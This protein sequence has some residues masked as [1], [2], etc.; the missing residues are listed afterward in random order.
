MKNNKTKKRPFGYVKFSLVGTECEKFLSEAISEGIKIFDV[1][2]DGGILYAKTYPDGYHFLAKLKRK[3]YIQM[4]IAEKRGFWL[5][6]YRYRKR[7]GVIFGIIAYSLVI[8]LC[9]GFVW[10]I[11]IEGNSA[12]SDDSLLRFLSDNGI[13]AGAPRK[14]LQNTLTELKAMLN[15]DRLAWISIE[16]NGSRVD[17]KLSETIDNPKNGLSVSTPCN[18]VAAKGGIIK[19]I[20]VNRGTPFYEEGSGVAEGSIVVSGI[21]NDG[22]GNIFVT[23]A[24]AVITAEFEESISFYQE[25]TTTERV[26][27]DERTREEYIKLFGFTFPKRDTEYN[28]D[29]IYTSD[30][31]KV[32]FLGLEMPWKR[33]IVEGVKTKEIEVTRTVNDVKALLKLE[34]EN[35]ERNFLKEYEIIDRDIS[36]KRDEKGMEVTCKYTMQGDIAQQS[37]IF[38]R[39]E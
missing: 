4:R 19:K 36:Y 21:V 38:Y 6:L 34:L 3:Y 35:Y 37:E 11:S 18:I 29:Y 26:K 2:N 31:Y 13:H 17:V 39:E 1:E 15:Y 27:T 24:D 28:E 8:L 25:F 23:H 16:T 5:A 20:E 12:I 14:G 9:S 10:D 22:A 7:Y 32:E 33:I 30:S